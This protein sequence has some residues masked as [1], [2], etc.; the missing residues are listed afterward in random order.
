MRNHLETH[1]LHMNEALKYQGDDSLRGFFAY[2]T[3]NFSLL[4]I[5]YPLIYIL[6]KTFELHFFCKKKAAVIFK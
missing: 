6:M 1:L 4:R 5:W 3:R 2:T